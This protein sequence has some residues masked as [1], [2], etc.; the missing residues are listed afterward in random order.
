MLK[1]LLIINLVSIF[2]IDLSGFIDEFKR[3][4]SKMLTHNNIVKSDFRIKPFDCSFC[5]TFW[6]C[7]LFTIVTGQFTFVSLLLIITV[8]YFTDVTRQ[9]LLLIKDLIIKLINTVYD[10]L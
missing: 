5:M 10:R 6:L 9:L 8:T 2:V 1:E 4:L 3:M 7:L